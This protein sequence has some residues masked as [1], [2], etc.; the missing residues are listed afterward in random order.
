MYQNINLL[1][2]QISFNRIVYALDVSVVARAYRAGCVAKE[3]GVV[4]IIPNGILS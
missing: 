4:I 1:T 3:N 2:S